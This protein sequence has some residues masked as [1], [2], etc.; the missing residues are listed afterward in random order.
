MGSPCRVLG[1]FLAFLL[2][3][4]PKVSNLWVPQVLT[5]MMATYLQAQSYRQ[6]K[7]NLNQNL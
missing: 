6:I 2:P 4:C 7:A 5:T 1:L 3:N